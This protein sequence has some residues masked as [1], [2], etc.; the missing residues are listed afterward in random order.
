MAALFHIRTC[1]IT[2]FGISPAERMARVETR[3]WQT[4]ED[5]EC[6]VQFAS[7]K[8]SGTCS[9]LAQSVY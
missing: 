1:H 4:G 8:N 2:V 9:G 6:T 7:G 3:V 5:M